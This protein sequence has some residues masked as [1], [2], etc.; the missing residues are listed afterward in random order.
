MLLLVSFSIA[1]NFSDM[2]YKIEA[3]SLYIKEKAF[4]LQPGTFFYQSRTLTFRYPPSTVA[5]KGQVGA[6]LSQVYAFGGSD[7]GYTGF[8]L[9][10]MEISST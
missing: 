5:S 7:F 4:N 9:F 2:S 6:P 3:L 10:L 1:Q 8:G